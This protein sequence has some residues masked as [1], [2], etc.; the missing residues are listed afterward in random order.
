ML[1]GKLMRGM[2]WKI[3]ITY[4]EDEGVEVRVSDLKIDASSFSLIVLLFVGHEMPLVI[5]NSG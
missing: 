2:R 4:G 3:W 1:P 5:R